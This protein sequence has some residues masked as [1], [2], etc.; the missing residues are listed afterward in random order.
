MLGIITLILFGIC[1]GNMFT[2]FWY[3]DSRP[4]QT[5]YSAVP[6]ANVSVS[7]KRPFQDGPGQDLLT[8]PLSG[9]ESQSLYAGNTINRQSFDTQFV[10]DLVYALGINSDR[11]F[12]VS[13]S[14]GRVDYNQYTT[15]VVV[16]FIM[17]ER[18]STI[19]PTLFSAIANLTNLIQNNSSNIYHG[20]NVTKAI[21][22]LWG[23]LVD[24]W[25]ISLQLTYAI[26][27]IGRGEEIDGYYLNQ[28]GLGACDTNMAFLYPAYC[29]FERF[30]ED[31]VS[32]ALQ[33]SYYRVQILFV[34]AS[35][36]DSVLVF[37]RI[38]PGNPV[39]HEANVT[40]SIANLHEQVLNQ[41]S[42]LYKGNVTIRVDPLWGVSNML[43]ASRIGQPQFTYKYYQYDPARL[44]NT[45]L[46]TLM[47]SYDR[48]KA[49]RRCNWGIQGNYNWSMFVSV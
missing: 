38:L 28:G 23:L 46:M 39:L 30:F 41:K 20:T 10:L 4:P 26:Q 18:N 14:P 16:Q 2:G 15:S 37:F 11:I 19:E 44:N 8:D 36:L 7:I 34:K 33:I 17:L 6:Y 5:Q 25:D 48:C 49:N 12:V 3:G 40:A 42:E 47:T 27:V 1:S 43:P 24:T 21:D 31:D 29:E 22:P 13:V 32:R 9:I 35:S 45:V